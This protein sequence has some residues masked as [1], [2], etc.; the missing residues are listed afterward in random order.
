MKNRQSVEKRKK[1][2][3]SLI[4]KTFGRPRLTVF[5]SNRHIYAQV[6]D[7]S[8]NVTI[9]SFSDLSLKLKSKEKTSAGK[10]IAEKVGEGIAKKA[11]KKGVEQVVF[12]RGEYRY[13]G[14]VKSLA[15]GARKEGLKF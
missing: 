10:Q 2:V 8:K 14:R 11:I 4:K 9:T 12:D 5:R 7:D 6:I 13:H 3:R 1:R 15:E